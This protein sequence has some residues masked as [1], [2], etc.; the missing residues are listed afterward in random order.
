LAGYFYEALGFLSNL[1]ARGIAVNLLINYGNARSARECKRELGWVPGHHP[2]A[3]GGAGDCS[4]GCVRP[5]GDPEDRLERSKHLAAG[6]AQE[7]QPPAGEVVHDQVVRKGDGTQ[8]REGFNQEVAE[9][10]HVL[11]GSATRKG[12][13]MGMATG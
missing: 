3:N 4:P 12:P 7:R 8:E 11:N 6:H 10:R 1:V 2:C 13:G 5:T 9:R